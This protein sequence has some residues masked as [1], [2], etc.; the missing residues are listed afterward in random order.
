M[1][2]IDGSNGD[3]SRETVPQVFHGLM[4][5]V[6]TVVNGYL[7]VICGVTLYESHSQLEACKLVVKSEGFKRSKNTSLGLVLPIAVLPKPFLCMSLL[8]PS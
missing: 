3:L 7:A 2:E 6:T 1:V 4:L 5:H 8:L